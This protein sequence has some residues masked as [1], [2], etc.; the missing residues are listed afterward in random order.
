MRPSSLDTGRRRATLGG[1]DDALLRRTNDSNLLLQRPALG[2]L[3]ESSSTVVGGGSTSSSGSRRRRRPAMGELPEN[4]NSPKSPK[5]PYG[6]AYGSPNS[7][8]VGSRGGSPD[9]GSPGH[10]S[11]SSRN[12]PASPDSPDSPD[13]PLMRK[14]RRGRPTGSGR[15]GSPGSPVGDGD[16]GPSAW[17]GNGY[18]G[19]QV[20]EESRRKTATFASMQ[21]LRDEQAKAGGGGGAKPKEYWFEWNA[22]LKDPELKVVRD[23]QRDDPG[24]VALPP[25][26]EFRKFLQYDTTLLTEVK[27]ESQNIG[28]SGAALVATYL[29]F[30]RV[31]LTNLSLPRN[32]IGI[33]GCKV[34]SKG[35]CCWQCWV[36]VRE[37]RRLLRVVLGPSTRDC[38]GVNG[39]GLYDPCSVLSVPSAVCKV[40]GTSLLAVLDGNDGRRTCT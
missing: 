22:E 8:A 18:Q 28:D 37:Q 31:A 38:T 2:E 9:P 27:L 15:P 7:N 30:E 13:S 34:R 14:P 1:T 35:G 39:R 29:Q 4:P 20:R 32:K 5:S 21:S 17:S 16:G 25:L 19:E 24:I 23:W 12:S 40:K 36:P 6:S 11:A 10:G 3:D 26:G 33:E